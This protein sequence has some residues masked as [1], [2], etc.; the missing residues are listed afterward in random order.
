[1]GASASGT[2]SINNII[3]LM[4]KAKSLDTII[5]KKF[6]TKDQV[7][8]GFPI[9]H[10]LYSKMNIQT[11]ESYI[12]EMLEGNNYHMIGAYLGE[13]LVAVASFWILTRFY[14]GRYI[15]AGNIVVDKDHR[16]LGL[17]KILLD[18]IEKEG[19]KRGCKKFILDSYTENKKSHSLYFREGFFVEGFHFMKNID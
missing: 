19:I 7:M 15:Q 14:C 1:L 3:S 6:T 12:D 5:I 4:K 11:Y 10:Q 17:G 18:Y 13:E 2:A 8:L 16:S 9:I